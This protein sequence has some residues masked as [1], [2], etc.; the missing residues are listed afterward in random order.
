MGSSGVPGCM[1][2]SVSDRKGSVPA[3]TSLLRERELRL[4]YKIKEWTAGPGKM[5]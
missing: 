1:G 5:G 2:V 4:N 3:S